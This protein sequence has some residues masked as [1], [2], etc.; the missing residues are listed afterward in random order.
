MVGLLTALPRTPLYARLEREGRLIDGA[1]NTDNTRLGT[2]FL[3]RRMEYAAM[4]AT[5]KQLYERLL[6]DRGIAERVRNKMRHLRNPAYHGEYALGERIGIVCKLLVKGVLPGGPL[7]LARFL[8]SLPLLSPA[9][10]PLAI[11][12]W[13][14][15]LAMR[16]YV[17]RKFGVATELQRD[18]LAARA[19]RLRA[20]LRA[21]VE[22][23]VAAVSIENVAV[24]MRL[25]VSLS[26]GLDR[27]FFRRVARHVD[28]LMLDELSRLTLRVSAVREAEVRDLNRLLRRLARYGDRISIQLHGRVSELVRVDSSVFHVV[29][30]T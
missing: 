17:A 25:S 3:P 23:G 21:Y 8:R 16:D 2:N 6:S 7:R 10:L 20:A 26:G 29:L 1:D 9:K 22:K 30:L 14:A 19:L 24:S 11:V 4:V 27:V 5:Y 13:I 15:G 12:D 28:K 18:R